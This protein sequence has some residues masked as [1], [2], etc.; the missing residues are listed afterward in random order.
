MTAEAQIGGLFSDP[1]AVGKFVERRISR[2]SSV[3]IT[4]NGLVIIDCKNKEQVYKAPS[5]QQYNK[6]YMKM[7]ELDGKRKVKGV[8]SGV[9]LTVKQDHILDTD[10]SL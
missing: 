5:I 7:F 6:C 3:R 8:I 4:R 1:H 2:V 9:L 10:R